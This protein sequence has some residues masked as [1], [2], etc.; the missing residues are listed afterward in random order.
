MLSEPVPFFVC[1]GSSRII[2]WQAL[3][4]SVLQNP[5]ENKMSWPNPRPLTASCQGLWLFSTPPPHFS[6][7]GR[8]AKVKQISPVHRVP[9]CAILHS[10]GGSGY[11]G[12]GLSLA[13]PH[14][15]A[16]DLEACAAEGVSRPPSRD[17]R[18]Q[19]NRGTR[20]PGRKG[21]WP[22]PWTRDHCEFCLRCHF[23][24]CGSLGT[25]IGPHLGSRSPR[26]EPQP[27]PL[28]S[29]TVLLSQHSLVLREV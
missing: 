5:L 13:G 12:G 2:Y 18:T 20:P 7:P 14:Q 29:P 10:R 17:R 3:S 23:I 15:G 19:Q 6:F 9:R 25:P 1:W 22:F 4:L 24:L 26:G 16:G 27:S 21:E 8:A 28:P 11:H